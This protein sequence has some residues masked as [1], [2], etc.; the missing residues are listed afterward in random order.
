[1]IGMNNLYIEGQQFQE[2]LKNLEDTR[3]VLEKKLAQKN[4]ET[5]LK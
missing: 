5:E 3:C 2:S 1:M 4:Y